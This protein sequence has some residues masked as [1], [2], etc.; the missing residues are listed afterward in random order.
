MTFPPYPSS[1][2]DIR[3]YPGHGEYMA[4]TIIKRPK[5]KELLAFRKL[6]L[7]LGEIGFRDSLIEALDILD[8]STTKFDNPAGF[9]Y[10][11]IKKEAESH[12]GAR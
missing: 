5:V 1:F 12:D 6:R 4:C 9:I 2:E 11:F 7:A 8:H 10:R 3:C